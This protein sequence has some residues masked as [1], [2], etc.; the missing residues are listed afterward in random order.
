MFILFQDWQSCVFQKKEKEKNAQCSKWIWGWLRPLGHCTEAD[1]ELWVTALKLTQNSGSLHWGW[2][3]ILGHGTEV[4]SELWVTPL[5]QTQN[6]GSLHWGRL[7]TLVQHTHILLHCSKVFQNMC[8]AHCTTDYACSIFKLK[9]YWGK[10]KINTFLNYHNRVFLL[11]TSDLWTVTWSVIFSKRN[12][13]KCTSFDQY[14]SPS[15]VF[16]FL[17]HT[18]TVHFLQH[19]HNRSFFTLTRPLADI[20]WRHNMFFEWRARKLTV[21]YKMST[22]GL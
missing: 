7:R 12:S 11:K 2:L 18:E 17:I 6:S 10:L 13:D 1:S 8:V 20:A 15:Q 14:W 16:K 9:A 19:C 3:S 5:R 4:D 22:R 21:T